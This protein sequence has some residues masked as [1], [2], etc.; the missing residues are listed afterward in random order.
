MVNPEA[1]NGRYTIFVSGPTSSFKDWTS[2]YY[3]KFMVGLEDFDM[4]VIPWNI[5]MTCSNIA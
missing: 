3:G 2:L 1:R 4:L 5:A